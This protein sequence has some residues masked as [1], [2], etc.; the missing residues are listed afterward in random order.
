MLKTITFYTVVIVAPLIL[1]V[2]F[3]FK[4]ST[5][6][7]VHDTSGMV[8]ELSL[9]IENAG[10]YERTDDTR[11]RLGNIALLEFTPQTEGTLSLTCKTK[12]RPHSFILGQAKASTFFGAWVTME[13]CDRP[14]SKKVYRF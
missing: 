13:S 4:F 5:V 9:V 10:S 6:V 2:Y 14:V 12:G 3:F 7:L 11:A 8:T 1:I